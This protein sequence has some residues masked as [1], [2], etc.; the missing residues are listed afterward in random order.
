[1][2]DAM[3]SPARAPRSL[4]SGQR[5]GAA[6]PSWRAA[7]RLVHARVQGRAR[8]RPLA[9]RDVDA[10]DWDVRCRSAGTSG[11]RGRS[12]A[13]GAAPGRQVAFGAR[14]APLARRRRWLGA[15][16]RVAFFPLSVRHY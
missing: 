4:A 9:S 3:A 2:A 8:A 16:C 1:M 6:S 11:A 10:A 5:T 14:A 13:A 7:A 15:T 12:P